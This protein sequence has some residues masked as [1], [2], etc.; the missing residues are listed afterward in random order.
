MLMDCLNLKPQNILIFDQ[1]FVVGVWG[2][3]SE[4]K[5]EIELVFEILSSF[6]NFAAVLLYSIMFVV[7]IFLF[8]TVHSLFLFLLYSY[9]SLVHQGVVLGILGL[10]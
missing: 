4:V 10:I 2:L 1:I 9:S 3:I 7:F 5:S 6:L 8:K